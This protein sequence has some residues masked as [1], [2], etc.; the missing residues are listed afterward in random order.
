MISLSIS[1]FMLPNGNHPI[2]LY[3]ACPARPV[4]FPTSRDYS[5][6]VVPA[7][8]TGVKFLPRLPNG[9]FTPLNAFVFHIQLGKLQ[10]I[11]HRGAI[12]FQFLFHKGEAYSYGVDPNI[13]SRL[14]TIA[15]VELFTFLRTSLNPHSTLF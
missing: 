5:S 10:L 9:M 8:G 6:G 12:H 3:P 7:D 4:E 15:F 13:S 1:D 14:L 2:H 11:F